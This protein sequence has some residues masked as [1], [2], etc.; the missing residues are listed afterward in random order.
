MKNILGNLTLITVLL[1]AVSAI[2]ADKVVVIPLGSN[3]PG[4]HY[5]TLPGAVFV[6]NTSAGHNTNGTIAVGNGST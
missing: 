1:F 2:A 5:Y 3:N 4:P 6:G